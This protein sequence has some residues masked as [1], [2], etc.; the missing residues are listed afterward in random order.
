MSPKFPALMPSDKDHC[1]IK[2]KLVSDEINQIRLD[3]VHFS[4]VILLLFINI[5]SKIISLN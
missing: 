1:S 3:F 5:N 2:I 4:L